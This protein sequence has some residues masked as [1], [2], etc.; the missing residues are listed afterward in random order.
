MSEKKN[1]NQVVGILTDSNQLHLTLEQELAIESL[2]DGRH[3][4][5]RR[6]RRLNRRCH[7]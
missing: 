1:D 6:R 3:R 2:G 4:T 7:S 5:C